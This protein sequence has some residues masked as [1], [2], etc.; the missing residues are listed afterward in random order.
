MIADNYTFEIAG[1]NT[2]GIRISKTGAV[3][4]A[5]TAKEGEYTITATSVYDSTKSVVT[6]LTVIG[7][8]YAVTS[9]EITSGGAAVEKLENGMTLNAKAVLT[10]NSSSVKDNEITL[11]IA[12]YD[13]NGKL[14]DVKKTTADFSEKQAGATITATCNLLLNGEDFTKHTVRAFLIYENAVYPVTA[15]ISAF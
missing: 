15:S 10:K 3:A 5:P 8:D 7:T 11:L 9:F 2:A 12:H 6:K 1:E 13:E 14:V 4:V